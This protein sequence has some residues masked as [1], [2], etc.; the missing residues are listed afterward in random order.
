MKPAP[1]PKWL[2]ETIQGPSQKSLETPAIHSQ[3]G[4]TELIR[5]GASEG[6]RNVTTVKL[7]GFLLRYLPDPFAAL[8][9]LLLWNEARNVPALDEREVYQIIES[10][11]RLE[12]KQRQGRRA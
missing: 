3:I 10:V 9:I 8:E 6:T 7:A 12:L 5:E 11:A 1:I 2:L 4:F